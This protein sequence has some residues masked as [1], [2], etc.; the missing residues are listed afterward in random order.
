MELKSRRRQRGFDQI[1]QLQ[2]AERAARLF[3]GEDVL[4]AHHLARQLGDV[5]LRLI[6][7]IEAV[8]ELAQRLGRLG[9]RIGQALAHTLAHL[10]E[11]VFQQ[12]GQGRL[13]CGVG[14]GERL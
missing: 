10:V 3:V 1:R 8:V 4:Q 9:R 5:L 7:D 14:F 13:R 11:A 6:D 2:F 12:F